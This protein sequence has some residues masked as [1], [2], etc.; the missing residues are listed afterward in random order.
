M[1]MAMAQ[2][3]EWR[4]LVDDLRGRL[5]V[6]STMRGQ[7]QDFTDGELG[8]VRFER[9]VMMERV[10]QLRAAAGLGPVT[11][12]AVLCVESGAAGHIDYVA[13]FAMGC[14]D[15]VVGRADP[16]TGMPVQTG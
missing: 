9:V 12:T 14:A 8:W 11:E 3:T 4:A 15:L 7:R 6:A 10:N 1:T 2:H 5:N 13:K 16:N